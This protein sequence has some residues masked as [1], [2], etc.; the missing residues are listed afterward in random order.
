MESFI[1]ILSK[2]I[3][4]GVLVVG[5]GW[6]VVKFLKRDEHFPHIYFEVSANF[7]GVQD[8]QNLF[9]VLALLE[10]KGVVLIKI[11]DLNFKV[12]GL[13]QQDQ[14]KKGGAAIRGQIKV[15][16]LLLEGS[17]IPEE[18]DYTFVYPGI[19]TEYNY[20]AAIPLNVSFVRVEGMFSYDRKGAT[21]G[22][23]KLVKVPNNPDLSKQKIRKQILE[24]VNQGRKKKEQYLFV[25]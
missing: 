10:N 19:N 8:N 21:H 1:D 9:E 6:G 24:K 20:I 15:P 7:I 12:R 11:R 22:A 16:H 4:F 5:I 18:W 2:I 23:A 13:L 17:W 3:S 25:R 14:I